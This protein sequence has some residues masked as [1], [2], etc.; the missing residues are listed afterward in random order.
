[1]EY[2][3]IDSYQPNADH[4][5]RNKM[6]IKLK[7]LYLTFHYQPGPFLSLDLLVNS[8]K[9]FSSLICL[10][11]NMINLRLSLDV[12]PFDSEKLQQFLE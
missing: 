11:L 8:I 7:Q 4:I 6:N 5:L 1:L 2:L 3:N 10:S 12:I 9:E